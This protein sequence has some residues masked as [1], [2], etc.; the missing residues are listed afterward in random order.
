MSEA[1]RWQC[2]GSL[3]EHILVLAVADDQHLL[4]AAIAHHE[5]KSVGARID[6]DE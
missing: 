2:L 6:G 1:S 3:M 5:F 4:A